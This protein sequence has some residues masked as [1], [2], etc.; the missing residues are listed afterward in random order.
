MKQIIEYAVVDKRLGKCIRISATEFNDQ[1]ADE[2]QLARWLK[3]KEI[4]VSDQEIVDRLAIERGED[5]G[6][7][8]LQNTLTCS[9]TNKETS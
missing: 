2:H 5:D 7:R 4:M 3:N 9:N 6:M 1:Y 8:I